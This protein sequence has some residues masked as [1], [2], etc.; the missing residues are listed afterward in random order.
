[1][2]GTSTRAIGRAA[3]RNELGA[4][5]LRKFLES[6][7]D[8]ITFDDLAREAGVSRSTFLR[9]FGSK[10]DV[11]LHVF[12]TVGDQMA[13]VLAT[14]PLTEDAWSALR[15][16]VAPAVDLLQDAADGL[17]RIRLVWSTPALWARLHEKQAT[18]RPEL[19]DLLLK[20]EP[21]VGTPI[22][23]VRTRVMAAVGCLMVAYDGWV[24]D[25]GISPLDE[26][27]DSAFAALTR[28]GGLGRPSTDT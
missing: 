20:R 28:S 17:D 1:M 10:E 13:A 11:V 2:H 27:T 4:V 9:Y 18:W 7:F 16:A 24:E 5:G 12:D 21:R 15:A 19:V 23:A 3:V 6:G 22:I 26:L 14:Q 25:N 8:A